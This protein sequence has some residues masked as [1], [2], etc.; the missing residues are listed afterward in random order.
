[1]YIVPTHGHTTNT[2]TSASP[3][4]TYPPPADRQPEH[5]PRAVRARLLHDRWRRF[6]DRLRLPARLAAGSGRL[7]RGDPA[8]KELLHLD[9]A[10]VALTLGERVVRA[11]ARARRA[12][13]SGRAEAL[14]VKEL[15]GEVVEPL[16]WVV[17]RFGGC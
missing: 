12:R 6:L 1:M 13:R 7:A 4:R 10:R 16:Q 2:L 17:R 9:E 11:R 5:V 15:R 8:A 3:A 14:E